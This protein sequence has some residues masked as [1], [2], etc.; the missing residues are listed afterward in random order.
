MDIKD[1]L[2]K[3]VCQSRERFSPYNL[4]YEQLVHLPF[5]RPIYVLAIGTAAYQMNEAV[6]YH[7]SQEPFIRIKECLVVTH[8]GNVKTPLANTT[9]LEANHLIPDENSLKAADAVIDFLQK[10][11]YEDTLLILL[12]GGGTA[13]IEKPVEGVSLTEFNEK[14]ESLIKNGADFETVDAERKRLSEVKG[15]KLL[16]YIACKNVYIYAMSDV[17]DDI[18]KYIVS[19]PFMPDAERV[20]DEISSDKFHRFDNLT[21]DKFVPQDKAI[22]YKIIANNRDFCETIRKTAIDTISSLEPDLIYIISTEL[23][24]DSAKNGRE[25]ANLANLIEKQDLKGIAA[26]A[27]PCLLIF[28]GQTNLNYHGT[29]VAGRST[30]LALAAVEGISHNMSCGLLAYVTDGKESFC[31]AAGAYV[32][33]TTKQTLLDKGIDIEASLANNDSFTALQAVD[34]ILPN[35][36]TGISVNDIVLLYIQ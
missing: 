5:N 13:L 8:Y 16:Q 4:L 2:V 3:L 33:N 18:P 6:L 21:A 32:D 29:G 11:L 35:E 28:G 23:A 1:T 14:V 31:N 22:T 12:S 15:G 30:E 7:A 34:A 27:T 10:R 19:N 9:C 36:N 25:I 20:D 17:P 24:G 26:F